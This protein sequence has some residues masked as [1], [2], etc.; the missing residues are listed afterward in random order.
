MH[1]LDVIDRA[2]G[3]DGWWAGR[4]E[5]GRRAARR[6]ADK[7]VA[8]GHVVALEGED[9][10]ALVSS[11]IACWQLGAL[12]APLGPFG[13]LPDGP[14]RQAAAGLTTTSHLGDLTGPGP[15]GPLIEATGDEP[16]L[17]SW[18]SGTTG[19]PKGVVLRSGTVTLATSCIAD[20]QRL[21]SDDVV[22]CATPA[23]SSFQLVAA[24]L[25]C[26]HAACRFVPANGLSGREVWELVD[27]V[28]ATVLV[29]YTP[30]LAE[31]LATAPGAGT[32][33]GLAMCGGAPLPSRLKTEFRTGLHVPLIEAYGQSELGGFVA[34]GDPTDTDPRCM[35][36]T[37]RP[38]P[39]RPA[40]TEPDGELVV[41][42][43]AMIGY[44]GDPGRTAEML[45]PPGLHTGDIGL[46]DPDGY[47]RVLGRRGEQLPDGR[48]PRQVEDA[49][50]D[51]DGVLHAVLVRRDGQLVGVVQGDHVDT[52]ALEAAAGVDAVEEIATMPRTSSG[53]Y[54]R[55][56][57]AQ[58]P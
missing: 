34:M 40:W 6:L 27:R 48:W 57:L 28:R 21:R 41:A 8:A 32:S 13:E 35:P 24:L 45:A 20:R 23:T 49:L 1:L 47:I 54:N 43:A 16:A 26:A 51:G 19:A 15:A 52:S 38:L 30:V 37:G 14:W 3:R 2:A 25:P 55:A 31:V 4:W 42:G 10:D 36:Y 33:L 17:L 22:V 56:A 7:G 58:V 11:L 29:A 5:A 18:T 9:S 53:K 50:F 46:Q 39:D 12:P 44:L